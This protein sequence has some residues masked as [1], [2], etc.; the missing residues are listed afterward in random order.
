MVL[1]LLVVSS[2]VARRNN[3]QSFSESGCPIPPGLQTWLDA[4]NGRPSYAIGILA[5]VN[6]TS[7]LAIGP[8][9]ASRHQLL[10][11]A[12]LS[13]SLSSGSEPSLLWAGELSWNRYGQLNAVNL[14]SGTF[15][16]NQ[17][18]Q[19]NGGR[20][21]RDFFGQ[22]LPPCAVV[23]SLPIESYD[24]TAPHLAGD[25]MGQNFR[26]EFRSLFGVAPSTSF[27]L[28]EQK[29][30][31]TKL[32]ASSVLNEGIQQGLREP[33]GSQALGSDTPLMKVALAAL[34]F[35]MDYDPSE[36]PI[37]GRLKS[38]DE[39]ALHYLVSIQKWPI[40]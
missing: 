29:D 28:N 19:A 8:Y 6:G 33:L 2:C 26:H 16:D 11:D 14:T 38:A 1:G 5:G 23:Q 9:L 3:A 34:S 25:V 15:K 18:I 4:S 27:L 13:S 24:E 37:N 32:I 35:A 12:V 31:E 7:T 21:I 30:V 40:L 36:T 20:R 17:D 22:F 10:A 39:L